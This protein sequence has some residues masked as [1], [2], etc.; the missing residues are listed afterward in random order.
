MTWCWKHHVRIMAP[1]QDRARPE[2]RHRIRRKIS[3]FN[4]DDAPDPARVPRCRAWRCTSASRAC[5]RRSSRRAAGRA[6]RR[7]CRRSRPTRRGRRC[8]TTGCSA[9]CRRS[10]WIRAITSGCCTG[11]GRFPSAAARQGRAAGARVRHVR[12]A[13]RRAGADPATATTGPSASTASSSTRKNFVWISGNG[14][15]PKPTG[16]GSGDDMILKFTRGREAGD[17]DRQARPEHRATPTR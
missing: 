16:P 6:G 1:A 10:P 8:R 2:K 12:Q 14:G 15:W 9:R 17:A 13:A 5:R 3:Q 11:R 7:A 4:D